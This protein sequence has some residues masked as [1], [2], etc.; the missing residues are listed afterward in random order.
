MTGHFEVLVHCTFPYSSLLDMPSVNSVLEGCL[1]LRKLDLKFSVVN[2]K[3][4][5]EVMNTCMLTTSP[6]I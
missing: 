6:T 2:S 5:T 4:L 3:E 1:K